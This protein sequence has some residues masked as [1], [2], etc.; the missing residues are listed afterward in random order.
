MKIVVQGLGFVGAAMAA[1]ASKSND[2]QKFEVIGI[3][4]PNDLGNMRIDSINMG[5][6]PFKTNDKNLYL[7]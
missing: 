5:E 4:L 2:N 3:D 7:S 6:F 1:I